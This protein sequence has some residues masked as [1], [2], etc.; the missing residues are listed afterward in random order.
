MASPASVRSRHSPRCR[1]VR[2]YRNSKR[3]SAGAV[4][5]GLEAEQ[6]A[7]HVP[8]SDDSTAG[9]PPGGSMPPFGEPPN[10]PRR[11]L[12]ETLGDLGARGSETSSSV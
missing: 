9:G 10:P 7:N 2:V 6:A 3:N 4:G 1:C 12:R 8:E 5:T 11:S